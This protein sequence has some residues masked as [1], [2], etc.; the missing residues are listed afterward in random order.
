MILSEVIEMKL[1]AKEYFQDCGVDIMAF[2]DFYPEG[3]QSGV[4]MI[5]HDKRLIANGDIRFEQTPGQWQPVPKQ[6][7]REVDIEKNEIRTILCYPDEKRHLHGF[8]PMIYPDFAFSYDV[9]VTGTESGVSVRVDLSDEVPDEFAGKLCFNLELF[10]G[11]MFG[12]PWIMDDQTGI[13]P[14]QPNAPT[15]MLP[16]NFEHSGKLKKI[17]GANANLDKLLSDK[18]IFNPIIADNLIAKPYAV[19]HKLTVCAN[20]PLLRF[21]IAS[22]ENELQLIDGRMNHNNGWFVVSMEIPQKKTQGAIE[23]TITPNVEKDWVRTTV[24]QVSQVGYHPN[25]PKKAVL[26]L[27]KNATK[28]GEVLLQKLTETGYSTVMSKK[29]EVFGEFLRYQYLI[30]DFSEVIEAGLYRVCFENVVSAIFKIDETVY[31][32]GVWQPVLEYFLPVQ[33]CHMRVNEK[34]RVWHG[35]CH[36]DDARMAPVNYEQ[37]DGAAQGPET[38]TNYKSGEHVSGLTHGG[39]H[40]AGDFDLRIESQTGEMYHLAAAYE[41]FGVFLDETSID[42]NTQTVEI[43]QPDGKNDILQQIEHG[44]LS[45]VGGYKSMGRL[46][47]EVMCSELRQYVLLGD[48]VN[49]TSGQIDGADERYVF[50]EDNPERELQSAARLACC[51]RALK[52]YNKELSSDCLWVA[53]ELFARVKDK[54]NSAAFMSFDPMEKG[55]TKLNYFRIYAA[56]ELFLSTK[57]NCYKEVIL[58][59]AADILEH[60]S[61]VGWIVCKVLDQLE[62]PEFYEK[63]KEALKEYHK[64]VVSMKKETPY[65][66]PYR[67]AI[68][69]AGW[70]IQEMGAKYYFLNKTFPDIFEKEMLFD[71]L[72]FILGMH[73]GSN[74]ESFVS[75]VGTNSITIGYGLNRADWSYIPGGVSSGTALIRPDFPELLDFPF[76]WQQ[77]EYMIS[78]SSDFLFLVMAVRNALGLINK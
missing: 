27:D 35:R 21:S 59:K 63:M 8:N 41:E 38:M 58:S 15:K 17:D 61:E 48:P 16:A 62:T 67:P 13:F 5:M 11:E 51:Y 31:E 55:S 44:A 75:G 68:W 56:C 14:V 34:Y 26:E 4:T 40:D 52:D 1:N 6:I 53:E 22:D 50:T 43:H 65:G 12:K 25:Q 77:K 18:E 60:V 64:E 30:F 45:V 76:L 71:S 72:N 69:G 39:W 3:H 42:Q 2:S 46:Y 28:F 10:P 20:D 9:I 23:F 29:P 73:P 74:T 32:R 33:M 36:C 54:H 49:M 47:H 7:K 19:G 66:I 70:G 24:I 78:A 57:K 37:F